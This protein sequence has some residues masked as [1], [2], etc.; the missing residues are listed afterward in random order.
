MSHTTSFD[1]EICAWYE[2]QSE[3]TLTDLLDRFGAVSP[4]QCWKA[5]FNDCAF[6]RTPP[7]PQGA[8]RAVAAPASPVLGV[9]TIKGQSG[10]GMVHMNMGTNCSAWLQIAAALDKH[11][12]RD[13]FNHARR[14]GAGA[15]A[16]GKAKRPAAAATAQ[17]G[18]SA[19]NFGGCVAP[20]T[21]CVPDG[22]HG[23]N[24]SGR[25]L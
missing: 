8:V 23:D 6:E 12:Q 11:P 21:A 18:F 1:Q 9:C 16:A 20:D 19:I 24:F 10:A 15:A 7:V 13:L 3:E 25:V 2:S 4:R 5:F 14:V 22:N 17:A